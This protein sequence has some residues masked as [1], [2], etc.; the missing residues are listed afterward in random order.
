AA[1]DALSNKKAALLA[2]HGVVA[3]GEDMKEALK[4]AEIV[5]KS[6]KI[7]LLANTFGEVHELSE[8]D[9]EIMRKMYSEEYGQ[10]NP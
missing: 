2:N 4:V 1:L 10:T 9:V 8:E 3:L 7:Y 6:A 5:E